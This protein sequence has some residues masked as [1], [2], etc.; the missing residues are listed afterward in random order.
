VPCKIYTGAEGNVLPLDMYKKLYPNSHY[1]LNGKP[2]GLIPSITRI[3]AFGG[4]K[5][6]QYGI[7]KLHLTH[8]GNTTEYPFYVVNTSG[9]TIIGLPTCRSMNLVTLHC[10]IDLDTAKLPMSTSSGDLKAKKDILYEYG[11]VFNGIG[12]F[13]GEF[14]ITLD[15]SVPPVIHP[16]CRV[17]EALRQPLKKELDS[18]E[19]QGIIVK[20]SEPTNWVNSLVCVT[21]PSGSLRLC[22]DPKDL[23][24]AIKRPHHC[25]P[26]IDE[27][28][29]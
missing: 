10:S 8:N 27:G 26:T 11:D 21:K 1:N 18:L 29:D 9:M 28:Y 3:T 5:I 19:S 23:N 17:P 24:K 14:H 15:S 20:V 22:L 7:S 13:N 6:E 12:C 2:S 4:H 16:P 25:T